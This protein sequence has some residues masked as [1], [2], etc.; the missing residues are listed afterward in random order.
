M[1][2]MNSNPADGMKDIIRFPMFDWLV[3]MFIVLLSFIFLISL[4]V[5]KSEFS[6]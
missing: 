6:N 2:L 1:I 4:Y 3:L 5:L